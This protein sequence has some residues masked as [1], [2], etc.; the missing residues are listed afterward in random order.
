MSET[1]YNIPFDEEVSAAIHAR[2]RAELTAWDPKRLS[3][4]LDAHYPVFAQFVVEEVPSGHAPEEVRQDWVG[5]SLPVRAQTRQNDGVPVLA[6]EAVDKLERAG[7]QNSATW[8]RRDYIVDLP[9]RFNQLPGV[10]SSQEEAER[11]SFL[12][13][14]PEIDFELLKTRDVS[15]WPMNVHPLIFDEDCGRLRPE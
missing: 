9:P 13:K 1:A 14:F 10:L 4:F 12:E 11:D 6:F 15:Y 8:W 5:L 2:P 3:A 7:R